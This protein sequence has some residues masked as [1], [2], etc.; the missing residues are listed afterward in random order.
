MQREVHAPNHRQLTDAQLREMPARGPLSP[1]ALFVCTYVARL[2]NLHV[3]LP[4]MTALMCA[5][6]APP[7]GDGPAVL[8]VNSNYGH[9]A[10]PGHECLLK[11]PRPAQ[12]NAP[13]RRARKVQGDGTCFNNT[14]EPIITLDAGSQKVYMVKCFPMTG[15]TQ[16]PGVV[17]PD[18]S[19]G[20]VVLRA[21][22]D[23]LNRL[24][25][26]DADPAGGGRL[27]VEVASEQPKM[28]NYKFRLH[29]SSPRILI[30]LYAFA[31]YMG[32]LEAVAAVR[33]AALSAEDAARFEGWDIILP[34][35]PVRETKPPNDDVK[36][37]FRFQGATR[38]PRTNVFQEGKINVLGAD[39]V[40]SAETIYEFFVE[41]FR[42]N[43]GRLV[44]LQP[45][46][47]GEAPPPP[48]P[49]PALTNAELDEFLKEFL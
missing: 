47:D 45:R 38:S 40:E 14:V 5:G 46:R 25:A 23:F 28:L 48:P 19:D 34:P 31:D 21:Y 33:G 26:G 10:L 12:A 44:A 49:A 11:A 29:R 41:L 18:L 30:N 3:N 1:L 39:T 32:R 17:M 13:R 2:S 6:L 15:E 43:W 35:Y 4:R 42:A 16:I 27:R 24:G 22:V 36:V 20:P 7:E 37:S 9:A 8:A